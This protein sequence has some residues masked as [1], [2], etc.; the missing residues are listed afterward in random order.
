MIYENLK[1]EEKMITDQFIIDWNR[2]LIIAGPCTFGSYEEIFEIAKELKRRGIEFL[3]AGVFKLRTSPYTFQGL[4][5]KGMDI[6][7]R[8]KEELGMHLVV[9]LTTI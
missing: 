4:G 5:D 3:R 9:E 8:I 6:L 7:L 2:P 1:K